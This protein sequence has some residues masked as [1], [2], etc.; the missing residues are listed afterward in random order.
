MLRA[1]SGSAVVLHPRCRNRKGSRLR[2]STRKTPSRKQGTPSQLRPDT[3]RKIIGNGYQFSNSLRGIHG[4]DA[5]RT[6]ANNES[7]M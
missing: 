7:G 5:D 3:R 4:R 1:S 2:G 6:E